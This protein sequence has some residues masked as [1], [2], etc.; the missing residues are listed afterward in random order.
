M[1]RELDKVLRAPE[2]IGRLREFGVY[3]EGADTPENK[4][5]PAVIVFPG[6]EITLESAA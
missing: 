2:I 4:C 1:N 6:W 5:H 3:T